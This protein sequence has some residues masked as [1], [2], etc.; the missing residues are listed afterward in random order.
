MVMT[1]RDT[2]NEDFVHTIST[3]HGGVATKSPSV[4]GGSC[5]FVDAVMNG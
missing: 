3:E 5:S 4:K 1:G 2:S